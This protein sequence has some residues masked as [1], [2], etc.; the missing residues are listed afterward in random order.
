MIA[1][2]QQ[3]LARQIRKLM[4]C[5]SKVRIGSRLRHT[6]RDVRIMR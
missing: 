2:H 4:L 3:G 6:S 5:R 1:E